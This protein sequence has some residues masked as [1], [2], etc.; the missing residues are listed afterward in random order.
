MSASP[1]PHGTFLFFGIILDLLLVTK[2]FPWFVTTN[3]FQTLHS[4]GLESFGRVGPWYKRGFWPW[5]T[6]GYENLWVLEC[7]DSPP[8]PELVQVWRVFWGPQQ[9]CA[10]ACTLWMAGSVKDNN[11]TSGFPGESKSDVLCLVR[12]RFPKSYSDVGN[13]L[14]ASG[15]GLGLQGAQWHRC[16]CRGWKVG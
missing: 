6:S 8:L 14:S 9:P 4:M 10:T 1:P 16:D 3:V 13:T 7:V 2:D 5:N 15:W 12:L 11:M